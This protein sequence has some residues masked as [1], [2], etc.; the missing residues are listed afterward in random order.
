MDSEKKKKRGQSM[1]NL[2]GITQFTKYGVK[3]NKGELVYFNISPTN[4]SVLSKENIEI[5]IRHLMMFLSAIPDIEIVCLDSCECFDEN[6]Q[7]VQKR[8][9]E[10]PN[11]KVRKALQND[12][13]F[14]DTIQVE[15]S[16]ARQFMLV[17]RFNNEKE[18]QVFQTVN[19]IVKASKEQGFDTKRFNKNEIKR[20]LSIYFEASFVGDE[21]SDVD[22]EKWLDTNIEK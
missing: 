7:Y 18:E 5:K 1:Q 9:K 17:A 14:F 10:E 22:G 12:L 6:K 11:V 3:T 4:I 19:R 13:E 21:M 15:M 2:I 20:F 16:S 8:L